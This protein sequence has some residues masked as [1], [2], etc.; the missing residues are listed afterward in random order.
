MN[1]FVSP[2]PCT[3]DKVCTFADYHET[4]HGCTHKILPK[5]VSECFSDTNKWKLTERVV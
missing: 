3:E 4:V 2:P 1:G 5:E